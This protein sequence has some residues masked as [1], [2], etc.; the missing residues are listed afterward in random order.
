MA[1]AI[2]FDH[3]KPRS[4]RVIGLAGAVMVALAL[5]G[6]FTTFAASLK[7]GTPD[8]GADQ[9][10]FVKVLA[11][12][13]PTETGGEVDVELVGRVSG[14]EAY[15]QL[16]AGELDMFLFPASRLVYNVPEIAVLTLPGL[17]DSVEE[18]NWVVDNHAA[19]LMADIL[20]GHG[21]VLVRFGE[22]GWFSLYCSFD[23]TDPDSLAGRLAKPW[24]FGKI[25]EMWPLVGARI[26]EE[27]I[28]YDEAAE[29]FAAGAYAIGESTFGVSLR[30][31]AAKG[32]LFVFTRHVNEPSL[33]VTS[34]TAWNGLSPDLQQDIRR[35]LPTTA[36]MR[37]AVFANELLEQGAFVEA[38]GQIRHLTDEERKRWREKLAPGLRDLAASFGGR[39]LELFDAIQA[40]KAEFAEQL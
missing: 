9:K 38:G 27:Q 17:W 31:F 8:F 28:P 34:K 29:K 4:L 37:E 15:D 24:F 5:G 19:P 39:S 25:R 1:S 22:I 23:C 40:G 7:V 36:Y 10:T 21:L 20:E 11:Q 32:A 14:F 2:D 35:T 13:I 18:R 26:L 16:A 33:L 12:S 3:D 30:K 6:S